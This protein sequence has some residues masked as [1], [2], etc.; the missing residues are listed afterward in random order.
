M[1]ISTRG[2]YALRVLIDLSEHNNGTYIPMKDVA[3]RQEI[4]LKYLERILPTLTKA[5][6]IEG[7]HGKGGGYKLTR[8]PEDYTVGEILRLTEGDLAPVACLSPDAEP[9]ERA[10]ECRTLG[11]WRG[12]YDLTNRYFDNI[13]IASLTN[14]N[15]A[16]N[17]II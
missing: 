14:E 6:L 2:R 3:A 10:A 1:M 9:C 16:D 17:Y 15:G 7:V 13:T 8:A 12:F 11:M 5:K 4:S